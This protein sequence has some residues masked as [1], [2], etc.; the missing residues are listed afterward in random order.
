MRPAA[1]YLGPVNP[2]ELSKK[3]CSSGQ[4][5]LPSAKRASR[6][7]QIRWVEALGSHQGGASEVYQ[8]NA[9]SDLAVWGE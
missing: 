8:T 7:M 9:D 1:A 4:G 3:D 5:W 2:Q 6:S